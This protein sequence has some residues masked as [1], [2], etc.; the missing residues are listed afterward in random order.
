MQDRLSLGRGKCTNPR[1]SHD[2]ST[3][4]MH[5]CI[6]YMSSQLSFLRSLR[7]SPSQDPWADA[8]Y[9]Y[10]S[11]NLPISEVI[12][13][14]FPLISV[15]GWVKCKNAPSGTAVFQVR[16]HV[17][18]SLESLQSSNPTDSPPPPWVC[19]SV[20]VPLSQAHQHASITFSR[21]TRSMASLQHFCESLAY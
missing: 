7:Q 21:K 8:G 17:H 1:T 5:N 18:P 13:A 11:R 20:Y 15:Y 3:R 10:T 4:T 6:Q 16:Q 12:G 9:R 19:L 2:H 14:M